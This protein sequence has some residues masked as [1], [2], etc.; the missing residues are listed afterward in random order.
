MNVLHN[1]RF[2]RAGAYRCG[3]NVQIGLSKVAARA[4]A[5]VRE[6]AVAETRAK[7][8]RLCKWLSADK[9]LPLGNVEIRKLGADFGQ[10]T[11]FV[12]SRELQPNQ[13]SSR[14]WRT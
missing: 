14:A 9:Q 10:R 13:V 3:H 5:G 4:A 6:D 11:G 7:I 12:A 1:N 8:E 2:A